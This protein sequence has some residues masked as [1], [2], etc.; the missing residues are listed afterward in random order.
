MVISPSTVQAIAQ[1]CSK[2]YPQNKETA[3]LTWSHHEL[4][5]IFGMLHFL[6]GD[7][8]SGPFQKLTNVFSITCKSNLKLWRKNNRGISSIEIKPPVIKGFLSFVTLLIKMQTL[9]KMLKKKCPNLI[10]ALFFNNKRNIETQ[11]F[12]SQRQTHQP[13][14]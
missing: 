8:C 14:F 12:H 13:A 6:G 11:R 5:S 2:L 3:L 1:F 9:M 7:P 4:C 10:P